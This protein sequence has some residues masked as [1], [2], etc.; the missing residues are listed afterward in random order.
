MVGSCVARFV[1]CHLI[2]KRAPF[3]KTPEYRRPATPC[4]QLEAEL[5]SLEKQ[6]CLQK[7]S[8]VSDN[9]LLSLFDSAPEGPIELDTSLLYGASDEGIE[10]KSKPADCCHPHRGRKQEGVEV[11]RDEEEMAEC[12]FAP[13]TGRPPRNGPY[14]NLRTLPIEDRLLCQAVSRR[15]QEAADRILRERE[16]GLQATCTFHPTLITHPEKHL[17]A[18]YRPPQDRL[19]NEWR[20]KEQV[21]AQATARAD[22][23]AT[24]APTIDQNSRKL[25]ANARAKAKTETESCKGQ[26][27]S[28]LSP[29]HPFK[30]S[31]NPQ[32][33]RI[34]ELSD[35]LPFDFYRRQA[36]F[37]KR[38]HA[39]CRAISAQVLE[40]IGPF[41]PVL[42]GTADLVLALAKEK[43]E[44]SK[45]LVLQRRVGHWEDDEFTFKPALNARSLQLAERNRRSVME[46][47][48]A[49]VVIQQQ[50]QRSK[51]IELETDR[52]IKECTFKPNIQKPRVYGYDN[53]EYEEPKPRSRL[54]IAQALEEGGADL[55]V[56]HIERYRQEKDRMIS[57][58]KHQEEQKELEQ[59]TFRPK[60]LKK[61]PAH[62]GRSVS[63]AGLD[64]FLEKKALA[65]KHQAEKE[66]RAAKVFCLH[67]RSPRQRGATIPRP[68]NLSCDR[69]PK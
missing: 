48:D 24:F 57:E 26:Q 4:K 37:E 33:Q 30:P 18:P 45:E 39:H 9:R 47:G 55:L 62:H 6:L 66:A 8:T 43:G 54:S 14:A 49:A 5:A 19:Y 17:K 16:A 31:L 61:Y 64:R 69:H 44:A 20:H 36:L 53:E 13:Q 28:D 3:D 68:F 51:R 32:S 2:L 29:L 25:A 35:S 67:P 40:N 22:A 27:A 41:N 46:T 56:Q 1:V 42:S 58:I 11:T 63:V 59:C 65:E 38:R 7:T 34:L 15:R 52:E 60:T 50:R 23:N 21:I 10:E 12:T